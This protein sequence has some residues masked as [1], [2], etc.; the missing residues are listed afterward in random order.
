MVEDG[1]RAGVRV[2]VGK[3]CVRVGEGEGLELG[4]DVGCGGVVEYSARLEPE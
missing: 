2:A 3:S 1:W 4:G